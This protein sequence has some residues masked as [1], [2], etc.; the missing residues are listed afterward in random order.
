MSS[1]FP[2]ITFV[3]VTALH[4][5]RSRSCLRV[6]DVVASIFTFLLEVIMVLDRLT[7]SKSSCKY[8]EYFTFKQ[9]DICLFVTLLAQFDK[10]EI[11][12]LIELLAR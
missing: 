8:L 6:N 3:A 10:S 1:N 7:I 9:V 12:S 2:L 5:D 11:E 4:L